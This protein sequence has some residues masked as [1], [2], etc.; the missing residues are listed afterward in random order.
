MGQLTTG[1]LPGSRPSGRSRPA[2]RC[3]PALRG[4]WG[5][6]GLIGCALRLRLRLSIRGLEHVPAGGCVIAANHPSHYDPVLL[7]CLLPRLPRF[8][9]ADELIGSGRRWRVPRGV[10]GIIRWAVAAS[11]SIPVHRT[12]H[13]AAALR[14][15]LAALASGDALVVF[16][17]G[18]ESPSTRPAVAAGDGALAP[19]LPGAAWLA[20][21]SGRPVV[22][23]RILGLP[24]ARRPSRPRVTIR[25]GHPLAPR[26]DESRRAFGERIWTAIAELAE[27]GD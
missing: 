8:L 9:A 25:F 12:G 27:P 17:E 3:R 24:A 5:L 10:R 6:R 18:G 19:P 21:R 11:S 2:S 26:P 22:P 1:G 14:Q 16:V 20:R 7:A 4:L 23:C 15:A 13:D